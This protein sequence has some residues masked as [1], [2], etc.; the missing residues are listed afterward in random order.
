M[1]GR[2]GLRKR[3][4]GAKERRGQGGAGGGGR[5]GGEGKGGGGGGGEG[6]CNLLRLCRCRLW[7][8]ALLHG[9]AEKEPCHEKSCTSLQASKTTTL[10]MVLVESR[11]C[12]KRE[13]FSAAVAIWLVSINTR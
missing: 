5:D 10:P 12:N 8:I 2:V 3:G 1:W 11:I 9:L 4:E 6:D 13:T 7:L